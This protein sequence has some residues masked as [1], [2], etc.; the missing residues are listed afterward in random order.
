MFFM[1]IAR[2]MNQNLLQ[3]FWLIFL[4]KDYWIESWFKRKFTLLLNHLINAKHIQLNVSFFIEFSTI[5]TILSF[6]SKCD[7]SLF[8]ISLE[9]CIKN[10]VFNFQNNS[11]Q[12]IKFLKSSFDRSIKSY[13]RKDLQI[14][15]S[16]YWIHLKL[17][18]KG[19][20]WWKCWTFV[21]FSFEKLM[22]SDKKM[23]FE[24]SKW[25][26]TRRMIEKLSINMSC[27]TTRLQFCWEILT[28]TNNQSLSLKLWWLIK[29]KMK[30]RKT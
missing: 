13:Q 10:Q 4:P 16:L 2:K 5:F 20:K 19:L 25:L 22:K 26:R 7:K 11:S 30:K 24:L 9:T 21:F 27:F 1:F 6:T 8:N 29:L 15:W 17:M 3:S 23:N 28:G 12:L 14:L 18:T